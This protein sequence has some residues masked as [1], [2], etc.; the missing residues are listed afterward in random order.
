MAKCSVCG[1]PAIYVMRASGMALCEKHFL[2]YFDRKVR[3]TIRRYRLFNPHDR[4][5]VAVSGGKDSMSLLHYLLR[6]SR[7]A[8]GWKITALLVDEGI[9]GYREYTVERFL[10]FVEEHS[11]EYR[12]VRFKDEVGY[13]LDEIV[14]IGKERGLPYLPC[15]YCGV[16]RRYLMNKAAREMGATVVATGHNL[17]D[18]IQTYMMNVLSNSWDKIARLGPVSGPGQH[19]KFVRKVKPFY[20]VLEKETTI[21]A[22]LNGLYT[23][24]EECPYARLGVRWQVRRMLNELEERTPG[25]KYSLLRSLQTA[26]EILEKCGKVS[27]SGEEE[28]GPYTCAICGEPSAHPI[29]RACQLRLELGILKLSEERLQALPEAARRMAQEAM[30]KWS[31]GR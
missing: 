13:T 5:A 2:E 25:V 11:V 30:S 17:D 3:R 10:R 26:I 21:Y 4:I 20:E 12:I 8:P 22:V 19:P 28:E 31:K 23:G 9:R 18:I 27:T 7:R 14:K 24:F 16:L 15:T 29:C 1:R 6:L